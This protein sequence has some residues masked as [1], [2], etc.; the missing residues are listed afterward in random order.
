VPRFLRKIR[1]ARWSR[2]A[3]LPD[4][5][6]RADLLGD[7]QTKNDALSVWRI[8]DDNSNLDRV[9]VALAASCQSVSNVDYA[10]FDESVLLGA[11][12]SAEQIAG[13]TP[14]EDANTAWHHDL[15]R[16]TAKDI[17]RLADDLQRTA[18][19][20]RYAEKQVRRLLLEAVSA[21][22]IASDRLVPQLRE[23]LQGT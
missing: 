7:F 11:K 21:G 18:E 13:E 6:L 9:V 17:L 22:R 16:L 19:R 15:V 4:E 8:L 14:D 20:G 3:W 5:E 1:Q 12:V 2:P 10:L 23:S